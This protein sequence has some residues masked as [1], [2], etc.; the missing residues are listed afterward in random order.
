M[1]LS[2]ELLDF[3]Q[4]VAPSRWMV[5]ESPAMQLQEPDIGMQLY[6]EHIDKLQLRELPQRVSIQITG[7]PGR[8]KTTLLKLLVQSLRRQFSRALDI[9]FFLESFDASDLNSIQILRILL[10]QILSQRPSLFP[11]I[12]LVCLELRETGLWTYEN[13]WNIA[14]RLFRQLHDWKLVVAINNFQHWSKDLQVVFTRLEATLASCGSEYVIL[15]T[16]RM[17][18][19]SLSH[20]EARPIDVNEDEQNSR[21]LFAKIK[22]EALLRDRPELQPCEK[23]ILESAALWDGSYSNADRCVKHLSHSFTM[24]SLD[25]IQLALSECPKKEDD[26]TQCGIRKLLQTESHVLSWSINV[27]SWVMQAAR[28][29]R[30]QELAVAAALDERGDSTTSLKDISRRVSRSMRHD[31]ER[32]LNVLIQTDAQVAHISSAATRQY[33]VEKL[34]K[35]KTLGKFKLLSHAQLA[36]LC[37]RYLALAISEKWDESLAQFNW[38]SKVDCDQPGLEFLHYAIR[39]W[40]THYRRH[41]DQ[42][43]DEEGAEPA[44]LSSQP[45]SEE[46]LKDAEQDQQPQGPEASEADVDGS[47]PAELDTV[48]RVLDDEVWRL[49]R[50]DNLRA[51]WYRLFCACEL[52]T[53]PQELPGDQVTALEIAA[54]FGLSSVICP[55]L[56][57]EN[58]TPPSQ[59]PSLEAALALAVRNNHSNLID[60]LLGSGAQAASAFLEAAG[61]NNVKLMQRLSADHGVNLHDE[62]HLGASALRKAAAAG[63]LD[64]VTFLA[65]QG[66]GVSQVDPKGRAAIHAVA[67][68]GM[69]QMLSCISG[70][71]GYSID[72]QDN[73]EQTALMLAIRLDHVELVRELCQPENG[74]DVALADSTGK[75]ALHFAVSKDPGIV[76][77]L[78]DR[79]ASAVAADKQYRTPLHLAC[80]LGSIEVATALVNSLDK[81]DPKSLN[82]RDDDKQTPLHIAAKLGHA[83]IV[84]LLVERGADQSLEDGQG[85]TPI[86]LAAAAGHLDVLKDMQCHSPCEVDP[87]RLLIRAVTQGQLLV[88]RRL[89]ED[90]QRRKIHI[91]ETKCSDTPLTIT[92]SRGYTE[93]ARALLGK[94][95]SNVKNGEGYA[96][97]DLAVSG[98][99]SEMVRLLLGAGADPN[100]LDPDRWTPLH[101][102]AEAGLIDVVENLL[103]HG[104][105]LDARTI[106]KDT[107]LH[108]SVR[109]PD[110]AIAQLLLNRGAEIDAPDYNEATP[111]HVAIGRG[112]LAMA[113]LLLRRGADL[114]AVDEKG[115]TP[116]RYAISSRILPV[117]EK[118]WKFG[119]KLDKAEYRSQPPLIYAAEEGNFDAVLVMLGENP[120]I[121][122]QSPP[123][124]SVPP[125]ESNTGEGEVEEAKEIDVDVRST[126]GKTVMHLAAENGR[127]DVVKALLK[128]TSSI[129]LRD[130]AGRSALHLAAENGHPKMVELL[131]HENVD[132]NLTDDDG[133]TVLHIAAENGRLDVVKALLSQKANVNLRTRDG[134]TALH[135][136]AQS[137][138]LDVLKALLEAPHETGYVNLRDEEGISPL[139]LAA[140]S[141]NRGAV[142]AL[143]D[144]GARADIQAKDGRYPLHAA[145]D[146]SRTCTYLL[147]KGVGV[148]VV[149]KRGWTPLM[150]AV[151]WEQEDP[152]GLFLKR[153]ANVDHQD[154]NGETVLHI[155]ARDTYPRIIEVLLNVEGIKTDVRDNSGATP[156]HHAARSFMSQSDKI[157]GLLIRN[158]ADCE[159]KNKD[160]ETPLHVAIACD[161]L[162]NVKALVVNGAKVEEKDGRDRTCLTI[163]ARHGESKMVEYLFKTDSQRH[164]TIWSLDDKINALRSA[165]YSQ[166]KTKLILDRI[167]TRLL[168]PNHG[169]LILR[170]CLDYGLTD[171]LESLKSLW[172]LAS[173]T[174]DDDMWTVDHIRYQMSGLS[175]AEPVSNP[176]REQ[177]LS[178][179]GLMV[180]D[181]CKSGKS[182][183]GSIEISGLFISTTSNSESPEVSYL[184][185]G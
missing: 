41:Y 65:N 104:A 103:D 97:L 19:P 80:Q 136:A 166:Y 53:G 1:P 163:A 11:N 85:F 140:W 144:A 99:H 5:H 13:L 98:R 90:M 129:N 107:A 24:S 146:S 49:L 151:Y 168:A 123:A 69:V 4:L 158:G 174:K 165:P 173:A 70:R 152:I 134:K 133:K 167:D 84:H 7:P 111:L 64:A 121:T 145:A 159:A 20:L 59:Q 50:N 87:N 101:R 6:Q 9:D 115:L 91:Q 120:E 61:Q 96:P 74:A 17:A 71:E 78:L 63:S 42:T 14:E 26:I 28:P 12:Q 30:I 73:D 153:G 34:P 130:S 40:P 105:H 2:S 125:L 75:T 27:T 92:A 161:K 124:D 182:T 154:G 138:N 128:K 16:S 169:F 86:E 23:E 176:P 82:L 156:L 185:L 51:K 118:V 38:R 177:T 143:M 149:D 117:F 22:M 142:E 172:E 114:D 184:A 3:L 39:H 100:V 88:V 76:K 21:A 132:I 32:Y 139:F 110:P 95:D 29:L 170:F 183:Y 35:D 37:I 162:A 179:S 25:L 66:V 67:L 137:R 57:P 89:L 93:I 102:A 180:P 56:P 135:A 46:P 79:E 94:V 160:G 31:L 141:G 175:P 112:S 119:S 108:L 72:A 127:L 116:L 55:F 15:T 147:D 18:I 106:T 68:G 155:A 148:D 58:V 157:I 62:N 60:L 43:G 33:L 126:S 47:N 122:H 131:L 36:I 45:S 150:H 48:A 44:E 109:L 113:E 52:S 77:L 171:T 10:H 164:P 81:E 83:E 178:P 54:E 8:G 181:I